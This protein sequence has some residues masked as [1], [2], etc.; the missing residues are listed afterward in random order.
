MKTATIENVN[1]LSKIG[2]RRKPTYNEI[3]GLID[4]NEKLT[5][6]LPKQGCYI[7]QRKSRRLIF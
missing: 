3:V 2:L 4:E 1:K 5:G 7:F 6:K